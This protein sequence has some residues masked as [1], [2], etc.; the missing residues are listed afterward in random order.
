MSPLLVS[1]RDT[2]RHGWD[3]GEDDAAD[4]CILPWR[5][6]GQRVTFELGKP[7]AAGRAQVLCYLARVVTAGTYT[8]EPGVIS[9]DSEPDLWA[10]TGEAVVAIR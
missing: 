8:W 5:I 7:V 6:E 4:A 2:R 1:R 10:G 9:A 3:E